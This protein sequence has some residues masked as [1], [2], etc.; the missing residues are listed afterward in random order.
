MEKQMIQNSD[1]IQMIFAAL[2]ELL[3]PPPE[4]PRPRIGFKRNDDEK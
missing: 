3:A 2:K 1:D 4:K